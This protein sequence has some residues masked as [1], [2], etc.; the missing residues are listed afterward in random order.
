MYAPRAVARVVVVALMVIS[1]RVSA[2]QRPAGPPPQRGGQPGPETPSILVTAFRAPTK[3]LAVEAADEL[4]ARLSSE[5]SAKELF[6]ITKATVEANLRAS[7]YPVDSALSVAD[8][9]EL[10]RALRGAYVIDGTA[11]KTGGNA[12]HFDLHLLIKTGQQVLT[13]PLPGIDGKDVGDA[14]KQGERA[15]SDALK[16][17]AAYNDCIASLRTGKNDD[18]AA[19]ARLGITAYPNALFARICLLNAYSSAKASPDSIIA[20]AEKILTIDSASVLALANLADAYDQKTDKANALRTYERMYAL[21]PTNAAVRKRL[22]REYS[23]SAPDK[24]L[25]SIDAALKDDPTDVELMRSRWL[26]LVRMSDRKRAMEAGEAFVKLAPDSA[27]AD[28]YNRMIGLAQSDSNS[29]KIIE[30][31][32]KAGAKFPKDASFPLLLA[33]TYRKQ[34]QLPQALAAARK[35]GQVDPKDPRGWLIAILTA[36]DMNQ[37]DTALAVAKAALAAGTDKQQLEAALLQILA[38]VV[39]KAQD[40]KERADWEAALSSAQTVD[41]AVP[42]P[43]TKF[44]LGLSSFQ[45]GLDALQNAQKLGSE[46]G[47]DAKESKVKACAEA[48]VAEEMWANATIAITSGG[49]GTYNKDGATSIMGAIQQYGEYIPQMKKL[50]CGGKS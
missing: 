2:Q 34:N 42:S 21:D 38:P 45:V 18:A 13:Q 26:V 3:E 36:K 32:Q 27:T 41:A 30:F 50:Y 20:V 29:A 7:G 28:F 15:I 14:A 43:A 47:K 12:T 8:L 1:G 24:A 25:A 22:I 35:A 17:M 6:V 23:Q 33:Q 40:S 11:K 48:K 9:M 39:K 5:H 37:P 31:A 46:K 44:Y 16:Q 4:R 19:K 10:A 49:G